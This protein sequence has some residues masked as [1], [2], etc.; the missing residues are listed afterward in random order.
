ML[1]SG[2]LVAIAEQLIFIV[3]RWC[4]HSIDD[5]NV[6]TKLTIILGHWSSTGTFHCFIS[7]LVLMSWDAI[8]V[9]RCAWASCNVLL[10]CLRY[11]LQ[12]PWVGCSSC[13]CYRACLRMAW[14]NR[15]CHTWSGKTSV[16][17]SRFWTMIK[18]WLWCLLLLPDTWTTS[19]I[20]NC[21]WLCIHS[22][23]IRSYLR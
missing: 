14:L 23:L 15:R 18:R 4:N 16:V 1:V 3:K 12:L 8:F 10:T 19:T 7:R 13:S 11:S 20:W 9:V 22:G 2:S 6:T 17:W 5:S 21:I